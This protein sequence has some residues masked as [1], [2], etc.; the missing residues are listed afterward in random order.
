MNGAKSTLLAIGFKL[1]FGL[2]ALWVLKVFAFAAAENLRDLLEWTGET[3]ERHTA[4]VVANA[5][6]SLP[7][8]LQRYEGPG[9]RF[10]LVRCDQEGDTVTFTMRAESLGRD[11]DFSIRY[12]TRFRAV[13]TD[14]PLVVERIRAGKSETEFSRKETVMTRR[15]IEG[16]PVEMEMTATGI[17]EI[18]DRVA[19]FEVLAGAP[20]S[21][22]P[23]WVVIEF[24]DFPVA[25]W[26]DIPFDRPR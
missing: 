22:R 14:S 23:E 13:A 21:S 17:G 5:E 24:H 15:L 7:P 20:D 1:V 26:G 16:V 19:L 8:A 3:T 11:Q 4:A 9:I 18:G 25:R 2:L 6:S 10:D 12:G